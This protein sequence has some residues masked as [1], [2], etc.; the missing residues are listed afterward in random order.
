MPNVF[1]NRGKARLVQTWLSATYYWRLIE[2]HTADPPTTAN[3]VA[4]V[5]DGTARI[6]FTG[7]NY[8]VVNAT[9]K[10]ITE[11]DTNNRVIFD[12]ADPVWANLGV[13]DGSDGTV[14][15]ALLCEQLGTAPANTD[16]AIGFFDITD[17]VTN[18][19]NFTL[20]TPAAG[21]AAG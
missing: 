10:A 8:A 1:P 12:C 13:A 19:Q 16:N 15:A 20:T 4:D 14:R 7:T 18:G 6:E 2:T 21:V 17:T 3:T 5:I 9:S 11:D